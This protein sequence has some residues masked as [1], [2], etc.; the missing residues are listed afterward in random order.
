MPAGQIVGLITEIR[1]V[2]EVI[3]ALVRETDEA[4]ERLREVR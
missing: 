1:P 3:E 4:L 2:A